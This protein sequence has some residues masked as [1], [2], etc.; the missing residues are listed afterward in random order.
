M[1][2]SLICAVA[3]IG[4]AAG[5]PAAAVTTI[6][7]SAFAFSSTV[8]VAS[9]VGVNVG[10]LAFTS[11]TASPAYD[12][13]ASVVSLDTNVGLGVV[14]VGLGQVTAGLGIETGLLTSRSN[15]NGSAP[16]DTTAGTGRSQVNDLALDLF[17]RAGILPAITTLGLSADT[18]TS[19]TSVT[20][21]GDNATLTGTSVFEDLDV[22]LLGLLNVDGAANAQFSPNFVLF[23]GIGLRIVLNEQI[24]G[25]NGTTFQ[26]LTTNALRLSFDD[27]LLGGRLLTGDVIVANS[28]ASILIDPVVGPPLPAVP[29]PGIWAQMII[30]FGLAGSALRSRRRR[31]A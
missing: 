21:N 28:F 7:T 17:T 20:L 31:F 10:P 18:I 23:D 24:I 26:S 6:S 19:T 14:Q 12:N 11:G 3:S 22:S 4:L 13:S 27:F 9:A 29:E 2:I 15:A 30:G 25:G 1:R 8:R 16:G 5:V